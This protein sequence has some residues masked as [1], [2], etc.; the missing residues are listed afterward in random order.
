MKYEAIELRV[1]RWAVR[2]VGRT[3][4][5]RH[6]KAASKAQAIKA[7]YPQADKQTLASSLLAV[8]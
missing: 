8:L 3:F 7:A 2:E 4:P 6:V 5:V 1:N